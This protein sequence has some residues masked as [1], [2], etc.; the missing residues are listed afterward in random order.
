[1]A[2]YFLVTADTSKEAYIRLKEIHK[3]MI[4]PFEIPSVVLS[5]I[6]DVFEYDPSGEATE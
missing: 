2:N 3:S 4:V 6:V 5:P 1:M